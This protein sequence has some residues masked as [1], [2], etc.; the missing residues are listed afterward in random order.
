MAE[1]DLLLLY[2]KLVL[3]LGSLMSLVVVLCAN[4]QL[5][6]RSYVNLPRK[7][8]HPGLQMLPHQQ[9]PLQLVVVM[10]VATSLNKHPSTTLTLCHDIS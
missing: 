8:T 7:V 4:A 5:T 10:K 3:T 1:G 9:C 2:S 6:L